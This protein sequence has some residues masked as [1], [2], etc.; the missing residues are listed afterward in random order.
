MLLYRVF[1]KRYIA[2]KL[3]CFNKYFIFYV[4]TSSTLTVLIL[5]NSWKIVIILFLLLLSLFLIRSDKPNE[6]EGVHYVS[7]A[8]NVAGLSLVLNTDENTYFAPMRP[9][10]AI[11]V[12]WEITLYTHILIKW[13]Y[14]MNKLINFIFSG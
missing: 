2:F 3:S 9:F 12:S 7:G 8:G 4:F 14:V 11:M 13:I 5:N 10:V 1:A 6:E